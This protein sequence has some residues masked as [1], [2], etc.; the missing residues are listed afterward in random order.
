MSSGA[1]TRIIG[2]ILILYIDGDVSTD[3]VIYEKSLTGLSVGSLYDVKKTFNSCVNVCM[4]EDCSFENFANLK[5][6]LV[7][8]GAENLK[9]E[10][11]G[12]LFL[13]AY[14]IMLRQ[15]SKLIKY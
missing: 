12:S 5:P 10:L 15:A 13:Y 7:R 11:S 6:H 2:C 4:I 1:E 9:I 8:L 14:L 3:T